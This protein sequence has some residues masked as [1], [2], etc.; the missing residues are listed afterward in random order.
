MTGCKLNCNKCISERAGFTILELLVALTLLVVILSII[1]VTFSTVIQS[2]EDTRAASFEMRTRQFLTRSF[3]SNL[4]QASEGWSPGAAFRAAG[5]STEAGAEGDPVIGRGKMRYWLDGTSTS[6]TFVSTAPLAGST[7]LP[8]FA[9]L[10]TYELG[11][12][13]SEGEAQDL[14]TD[15]GR[16]PQA[17]LE[18]T[19]TPLA[20]S[21][22]AFGA[23]LGAADFTRE[24]VAETAESIGMKSSGWNIPVESILFQYFDGEN[25]VDTWDSLEYGR[26]PW[27]VDV[28]I[29]FP[30]PLEE[31]GFATELDP[32]EEAD[33]RLVF[34]VPVG[35]GVRD[36]PP[37]YIR[38]EHSR[39]DEI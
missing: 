17:T 34:T 8:G 39:R 3:M 16:E 20:L 30:D 36:E 26:L 31:E 7:G 25:W 33:F 37:D 18:V 19:E 6:L 9:K 14:L 12:E 4:A 32:D 21:G 28:R 29:N 5:L 2:T 15:F 11:S 38:P 22:S 1:Y 24:E 35:V 10:V 27:A 23:S 13:Q